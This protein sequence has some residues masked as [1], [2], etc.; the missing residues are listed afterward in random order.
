MVWR[1]RSGRPVGPPLQQ[2]SNQQGV[3]GAAFEPRRSH[4]GS[5]FGG[6]GRRDPRRRQPE[7]A[8]D[9]WEP[10]GPASTACASRRTAATLP[11]DGPRGLTQLGVHGT[12]GSPSAAGSPGTPAEVM[13]L[14]VS[15]D[16]RTLATGSMDGTIRL[17]DLRHAPAAG[18]TAAGGDE[19]LG[20][21]PL[22][23][24]RR[25]PVRDHRRRAGPPL[26]HAH[27]LVGTP[28]LRRRRPHAH[29][30]RSGTTSLPGH[31]Y[32]PACGY[33]SAD[34]STIASI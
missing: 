1:L 18:G 31:A 13:A 14:S 8:R 28:R 6:A 24:R 10:P 22:H 7:A 23:A 12:R 2:Y 25:V 33:P 4:A 27:V 17:F 15:P 26:G 30:R 19:P 16:G 3:A 21:A 5:R 32:A 20:R 29:P 9:G 11:S 34:G